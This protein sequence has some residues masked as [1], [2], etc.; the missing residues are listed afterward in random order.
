[1]SKYSILWFSGTGNTLLCARALAAALAQG[2]AEAE[3]VDISAAAYWQPPTGTTL[4][5]CWPVY[6]FGPPRIVRKF[7]KQMPLGG[8]RVYQLCT[9]GGGWRRCHEHGSQTAPVKR[10]S[11]LRR[12]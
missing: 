8:N 9:L 3:L 10:L 7:I 1:M 4:I 12:H 6:C 5:F 11:G 2:G